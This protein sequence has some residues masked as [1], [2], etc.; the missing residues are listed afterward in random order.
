[1]AM[2]K[3]WASP[4][5]NSMAYFRRPLKDKILTYEKISILSNYWI[6]LAEYII[7]SAR[8]DVKP[9]YV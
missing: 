5:E 2:L 6:A 7:R 4:D 1:M 8:S 3:N 9:I